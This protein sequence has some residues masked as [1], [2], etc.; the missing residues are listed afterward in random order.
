MPEYMLLLYAPETDESGERERWAEMPLWE[1]VTQSLREAGVLLANA[2]LHSPSSATTVR[3]RTG[4]VELVD[5]P[6]AT[7]K[8]VL[9][10]YYL[11]RCTDLDEALGHAAR[12]PTARYG[13]VEV[14]PVVDARDI[15]APESRMNDRGE[16]E[17]AITRVFRNERLAILATLIR[18]VGDFQLAEDAMQDAFASA[19]TAWPTD[20]VPQKPGAW[21]TTAARRRAIDL[22][23][24]DRSLANRAARLAELMRL[25]EQGH[26]P[27]VLDDD[28]LR[29]IFTCC[30][31][32]LDM[33]A[34]VALT[35]RTVG[36]L[37]TGEIAKAFLVAEPTM[38]KRIVRAKRK[39][40]DAHIR[41]QI[42]APDELP[43]RL[44]GVLRVVY[45]IFSEGYSATNG[46]RLVRGDL[47]QEAIR[48][49]RLLCE[50]M[51]DDTEVWGLLALMLLH[52]AR[53]RRAGG[54]ARLVR[55]PGAARPLAVGPRR[56]PR[57]P[58]GTQPSK[59][60]WPVPAAGCD[61][62]PAHRRARGLGTDR[63]HL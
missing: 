63:A 4:E 54:R 24:H 7:T 19:I 2:P 44:R 58:A 50:L 22:L 51:P 17:D 37:S 57:R 20:G 59:P 3:V 16:A 13:S 25:D 49:G 35:L 12:L 32:A 55:Q 11:L 46:E 5:G 52:N 38:G 21:I 39:I 29:L 42:P 31:P 23:R 26:P 45:L 41:Y 10:G 62:R 60:S 15:P 33:S 27:G 18:Q 30:H 28:R 1:E 48:L 14:R 36:G 47:C 43:Q 61:H 40:A 34:R 8:E 9:A 56:H 6:F 53:Q